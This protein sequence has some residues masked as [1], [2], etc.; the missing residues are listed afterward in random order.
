MKEYTLS[1]WSFFFTFSLF[2]L[3][4]IQVN[5]FLHCGHVFSFLLHCLMHLWWYLCLQQ[6]IRVSSFLSIFT[7]QIQHILIS[8]FFF[9][10]D[11][12]FGI[13]YW[14]CTLFI[15]PCCYLQVKIQTIL[16][17]FERHLLPT[18][19]LAAFSCTSATQFPFAVFLFLLI[20]R[21]RLF[22]V[23][24]SSFFSSSCCLSFSCTRRCNTQSLIFLL[25]CSCISPCLFLIT[26]RILLGGP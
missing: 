18:S 10:L 2:L 5:R 4:T 11:L 24:Y 6:V 14:Q 13:F 3:C 25:L 7:I 19:A 22:L 9:T 17:L 12:V 15:V 21:L 23:L 8:T 1:D 16:F 26:F 20:T